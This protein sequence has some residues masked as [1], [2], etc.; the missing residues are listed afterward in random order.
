MLQKTIKGKVESV[1][2]SF[3]FVKLENNKKG[4]VHISEI[5]DFFIRDLDN[6]FV[7][8]AEFDFVIIG[9]KQMG[10]STFFDLSFKKNRPWL[11]KKP[12][13]F[14]LLSSEESFKKLYDNTLKH[15]EEQK[16]D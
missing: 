13:D 10:S 8:G 2:K 14:K 9:E 11:Q 4:R 12:F 16:N 6:M 1:N 3:L 7:I 15:I 5:S